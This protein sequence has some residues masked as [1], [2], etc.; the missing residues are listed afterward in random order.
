LRHHG[1]AQLKEG[2][3]PLLGSQRV[4]LTFRRAG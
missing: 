3:H 4:N 1:V 2:Y